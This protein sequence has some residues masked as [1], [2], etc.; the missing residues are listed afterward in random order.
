MIRLTA[1]CHEKGELD[2]ALPRVEKIAP[3]IDRAFAGEIV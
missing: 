3:L 2:A 1:G